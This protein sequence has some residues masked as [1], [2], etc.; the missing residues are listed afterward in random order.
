M[1]ELD[2]MINEVEE[3]TTTYKEM[4]EPLT[5]VDSELTA[6]QVSNY[7]TKCDAKAEELVVK[8]KACQEF[9]VANLAEMRMNVPVVKLADGEAPVITL[10]SLQKKMSTMV[11]SRESAVR[12]TSA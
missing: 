4:A 12:A 6:S 10:E 11:G 7:S 5:D 1:T 8:A 9:L 2:N 3:A